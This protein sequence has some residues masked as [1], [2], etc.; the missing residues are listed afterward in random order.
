VVLSDT[1]DV[2]IS[3]KV[4]GVT[5]K[6]V[7][8]FRGIQTHVSAAGHPLGPKRAVPDSDATL[9]SLQPSGSYPF[10]TG[11]K[12]KEDNSYPEISLIHTI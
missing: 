4:S 3:R 8:L 11:N 12:D 1:L 7:L 2:G 9:K 10:G 6:A 5:D